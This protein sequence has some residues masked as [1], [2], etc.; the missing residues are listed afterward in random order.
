MRCTTLSQEFQVYAAQSDAVLELSG[1]SEPIIVLK[2]C[3]YVNSSKNRFSI[4]RDSR[5]SLEILTEKTQWKFVALR[6]KTASI[7]CD[8][9]FI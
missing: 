6:I 8:T 1:I 9:D 3:D 7:F 4:F 5:R 2:I